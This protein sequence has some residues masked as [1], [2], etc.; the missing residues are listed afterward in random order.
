MLIIS[1]VILA[2]LLGD[3]VF[4]SNQAVE[5]RRKNFAGR[6]FKQHILIHFALLAAVLLLL[7]PLASSDL[8]KQASIAATVVLIGHTILDIIKD[9]YWKA[10]RNTEWLLGD[11]FGHFA[12]IFLA[13]LP[14]RGTLL[15]YSWS[16][17][18]EYLG[19]FSKFSIAFILLFK[20][21]PMVVASLLNQLKLGEEDKLE[22]SSLKRAGA[23]I[24]HLERILIFIFIVT[25]HWEGVGFLLAA[26]SIFR[27]GDLTRK[28]HR[29]Q[30]EYVLLGTLTSFIGGILTGQLYVI[31]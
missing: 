3:F 15:D 8:I 4:Q 22:D 27:Y 6:K 7:M 5:Q 31:L 24:G 2:H 18:I 28:E 1:L 9:L 14:V 10:E 17:Y 11:Q 23:Y 30:T 25:G 16:H 12:I 29:M 19:L 20:V 13:F 21:W 26:K